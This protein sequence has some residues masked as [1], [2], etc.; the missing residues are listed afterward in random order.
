MGTRYSHLSLDDRVQIE[1]YFDAGLS[2]TEIARRIGRAPS[3]VS[4]E[5]NSRSWRPS[6]TSWAY[7][8]YG[9]HLKFGD[10]SKKQYRASIA[11]KHAERRAANSH[12][13]IKMQSDRLVAAVTDGLRSGWT[14]ETIAGRLKLSHPA[15]PEMS[16]SH[17]TIYGWIYAPKQRERQL[18]QYL[19][20]GHK[21]R[22]KRKGRRV[23]SQRINHRVSISERPAEVAE[24]VEFGHWEA[25][26][27]LGLRGSGVLHTEVERVSRFL[28]AE[29][30]SGTTAAE[31]LRAQRKL[32]IAFPAHAVKS[33][34]ADNGSEFSY[35]YQLAD[36]FGVPTYFAD[37]YSSYQRGSNE[38]R[39]GKVRV[40]LPKGTSFEDLTDEELADIVAEINNRPLRVLGWRTP[41]EVFDE[42]C[43]G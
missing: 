31:A 38:N 20:R 7:T 34:T 37:P 42:L 21:K 2:K 24:R 18:W 33:I 9:P 8:D 40:Y 28:V 25:D 30:V 26:S 23:R 14:P 5:I 27:V 43:L 12:K 29:K 32:V 41:A 36:E 19:P 1:K 4:R 10:K 39:N 16:V 3:T 6:N 15:D 17:E 13:P 22:R 11:E 35:H